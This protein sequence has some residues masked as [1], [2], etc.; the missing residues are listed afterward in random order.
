MTKASYCAR[1]DVAMGVG[2]AA[3]V[4]YNLNI[5]QKACSSSHGTDRHMARISGIDRCGFSYRNRGRPSRPRT[6]V[7]RTL[8][9][10]VG[11]ACSNR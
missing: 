10:V 2:L 7:T 4:W 3:A 5:S 1:S 11:L 8:C 6:E 9:C